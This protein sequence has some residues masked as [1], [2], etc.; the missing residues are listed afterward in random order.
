MVNLITESLF[1][2]QVNWNLE[3]LSIHLVNLKEEI[4]VI[5]IINLI[6]Q[7]LAPDFLFSLQVF[8]QA[9]LFEGN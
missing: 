1:I 7:L 6:F 2:E 8:V 3:N 9:Y 4:I 5:R